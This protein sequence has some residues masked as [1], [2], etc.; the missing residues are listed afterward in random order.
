MNIL[1]NDFDF[2]FPTKEKLSE[3]IRMEDI[4]NRLMILKKCYCFDYFDS[5]TRQMDNLFDEL[6]R[7]YEYAFSAGGFDEYLV[8][9]KHASLI[10][11]PLLN[12]KNGMLKKMQQQHASL[13][14]KNPS[15]YSL[16]FSLG[17]RKSERHTDL[18]G[19]FRVKYMCS[20]FSFA[21]KTFLNNMRQRIHLKCKL[22]YFWCFLKEPDGTPYIHMNIYFRDGEF[23]A[24]RAKDFAEL[25][26]LVT[27]GSG[28]SILFDFPAGYSNTEVYNDTLKSLQLNGIQL[29]KGKTKPMQMVVDD[30]NG[31]GNSTLKYTTEATKKSFQHY[32]IQLARETYP[33]H[34]L[35]EIS[36][37]EK[38]LVIL[39]G[40]KDELKSREIRGYALS[41]S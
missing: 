14:I 19:P 4:S 28:S 39:G 15:L 32:L 36:K 6:A 10:T 34:T 1:K 25:W 41:Q 30:Y 5:R 2:V 11:L 35:N 29:P 22:G 7:T 21:M 17:L 31:I 13:M 40:K 16:R 38:N 27:K 23:N 9:I 24:S 18:T 26:E 37:G 3:I 33:V 12:K 8:A 20:I